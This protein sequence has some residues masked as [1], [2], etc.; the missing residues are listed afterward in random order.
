MTERRDPEK[1]VREIKRKCRLMGDT[2]REATSSEVTD[3][4]RENSQL[5]EM[6][7]E[8]SADDSIRVMESGGD[9]ASGLGAVG[10]WVVGFLSFEVRPGKTSIGISRQIPYSLQH[11]YQVYPHHQW[12]FRRGPA[13]GRRAGVPFPANAGG[14]PVGRRAHYRLAGASAAGSMAAPAR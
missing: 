5:K 2:R 8:M 10:D 1:V 14:A 7:A 6:L 11:A 13:V 3:L 4:R 12:H 9:W